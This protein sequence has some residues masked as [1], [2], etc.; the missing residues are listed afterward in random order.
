MI[1]LVS[2]FLVRH[3]N[4]QVIDMGVR[5]GARRGI[6]VRGPLE[7][8]AA[9]FATHLAELGYQRG[10]IQRHLRM[11]G[12]LSQWMAEHGLAPGEL[13]AEAAAPFAE[14]MRAAGS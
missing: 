3:E 10:S 11:M 5:P 4:Q 8:Y 14:I 9:G 7:M 12:R 1:C 6:T 2:L 13:T